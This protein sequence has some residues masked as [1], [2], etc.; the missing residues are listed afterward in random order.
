M[1]RN[2]DLFA[3]KDSELGHTDTVKMHI[4]VGVDRPIKM[5]PYRT[6][7]KNREV[8][9][10]AIDE[11]LD[12][13]AIK[14]FRS[15]RSFPVIIVDKKNG[16]KRFCIDFRKLNQLTKKNSHPLPL[17]GDILALLGKS[18]FFT[19]LDLKSG[20]WQVAMDVKDKVVVKVCLSSMSC[21][22]T[23]QT[24]SFRSSCL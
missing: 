21:T 15:P 7:I 22:L 5:R 17:I 2:Q 16:S 4:D 23:L 8:I 1:L 24:Q 20:Y 9:D 19:S 13:D 11:M 10:K 12:A 18:K 14:R 3:N 6:P